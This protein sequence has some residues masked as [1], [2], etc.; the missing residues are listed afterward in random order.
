MYIFY[1]SQAEI[2][3]RKVRKKQAKKKKAETISDPDFNLI[4]KDRD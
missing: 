3:E 1:F 2:A 4:N